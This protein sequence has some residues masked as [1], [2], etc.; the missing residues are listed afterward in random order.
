RREGGHYVVTGRKWLI[1][2]AQGAAF[3]IIMARSEEGATMLLAEMSAP[4]IAIERVLDTI[5]QGFAG[6]HAVLRFED[7]RVPAA[8]VLGAPGEGFKYAQVRLAPA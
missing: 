5:D 4:G 7:L 3:A 8:N 2:G 6:G 1:T